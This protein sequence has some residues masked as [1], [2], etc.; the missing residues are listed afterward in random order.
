MVEEAS[1]LALGFQ[2][3]DLGRDER[4]DLLD[5]LH[6]LRGQLLAHVP[7]LADVFAPTCR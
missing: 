4:V 7:S 5:Q 1:V 3:P 2:R 6:D